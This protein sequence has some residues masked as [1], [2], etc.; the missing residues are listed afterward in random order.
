MSAQ[1]AEPLIDIDDVSKVYTLG[2]NELRA[3]DH[4]TLSVNPGE[5]VAI[6]GSSGSGKSTLMNIIGCLDR[7]TSG[8]YRLS[9]RDVSKLGRAELAEVRNQMIGFVFQSFNL[10]PRTAAMDN[11]ELPLIY[12]GVGRSERQER[13][14]VAL[15][16]VGLGDRLQHRP[17]QLSGGQQQRVAIAR[18]IVNAPRIVLADEPTG[19]L[20]TKTSE[21]VM[22][23][24]QDLWRAGLTI[25]Y[26]THEPDVARYASRVIIL[27]DGRIQSDVSQDALLVPRSA[28]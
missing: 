9:G 14:R 6:M 28:A 25:V 7:P 2:D 4:I 23:L 24:F 26:V 5:F 20:D 17:S 15:T 12:A 19:N 21:A 10:L 8:R 22:G 27:R 16:R 13:A 18:A 1:Q 11:V 3:L